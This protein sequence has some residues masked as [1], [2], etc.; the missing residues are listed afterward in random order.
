[1]CSDAK[2]EAI[3]ETMKNLRRETDLIPRPKEL[4]NERTRKP[5]A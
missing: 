5:N 2:F 3:E 4:T 1:V